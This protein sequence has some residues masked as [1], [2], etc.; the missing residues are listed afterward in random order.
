MISEKSEIEKVVGL[1]KKR[2]P[3]LRVLILV[4]VAAALALGVWFWRA[5]TA[6][7]STEVY[8]TM[9]V[10]R[11]D[12][13]VTVNATGTVE[14]TNLVEISSELSGRLIAV[15]VDYN[16]TVT[17]GQVLA[18]LDPETRAAQVARS[19]A[20]LEASVAHVA[21]ADATVEESNA[22]YNRLITLSERNFASLQSLQSAKAT[23]DRAHA[24]ADIA[25][26]NAK[27]AE[28]DLKIDEADLAKTHIYS[29]IKGVVLQR[30]V[31]VGQTIAASLS[32]PV[33]F[34]IAEDLSEME[35]Q[36]D[37]DEADVGAVSIGQTA[38]FTVEAFQNRKFPAE[39]TQVRFAS[40]TVDGVVTYR[41]ILSVDNSALLLRPG[42][43][44]TAEITV[45]EVTDAVL[46]PNAA[47]RFSPPEVDTTEKSGGSGLL[48]LLI[49][50]PS[51]TPSATPAL[52]VDGS[53]QI[54][55]LKNGTAVAV[56]V[57]TG[58]TDGDRTVITGGDIAP[59][60]KIIT[61]LAA[62]K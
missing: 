57:Q 59:G 38:T 28:A 44:A 13:T 56:T 20:S 8:T 31:D 26:A 11:G 19:R 48:G 34:S 51:D 61:D 14:P 40:E 50:R 9:P 2:R 17:A 36:V 22:E 4:A 60:A 5:Q 30:N 23:V 47:L 46:I 52:S 54:W 33:L 15:N 21:E 41:A 42:M 24:L 62:A 6:A 3:A 7:S 37:I 18:Q 49:R 27:V 58:A 35:L 55:V 43:T 10:G 53:R 12:L 1:G 29:P 25:R 39:I 32:A 16:S 45:A